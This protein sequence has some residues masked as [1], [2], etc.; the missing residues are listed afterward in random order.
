M[1]L[2]ADNVYEYFVQAGEI[3]L[4]DGDEVFV[5]REVDDFGAW[6]RVEI[7]GLPRGKD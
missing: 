2:L 3:E 6:A 7:H 4:D 1:V 5:V